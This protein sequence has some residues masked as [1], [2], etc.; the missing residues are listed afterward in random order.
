MSAEVEMWVI[1]PDRVREIPRHALDA[2]PVAWDQ[3]DP[4][5]DRLFNTK[6][7]SSTGDPRAAFEHV[8][9]ADVEWCLRAL[10]VKEPGVACRERLEKRRDFGLH[11]DIV[12][13]A[14]PVVFGRVGIRGRGLALPRPG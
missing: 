7:A 1:D 9:G 2:L 11:G 14:L 6:G 3:V 10:G 13:P 8:D 5:L 12:R 4:L